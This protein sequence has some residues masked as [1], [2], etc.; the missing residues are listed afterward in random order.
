M[1]PNWAILVI[2][3]HPCE[4]DLQ[5]KQINTQNK[6]KQNVSKPYKQTVIFT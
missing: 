5:I 6:T 2:M 4:D 3:A 1:V